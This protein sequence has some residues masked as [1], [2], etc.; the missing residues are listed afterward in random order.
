MGLFD[1]VTGMLGSQEGE[2]G[3]LQAI[4]AWLNDQGGIAGLLEKFH[5]GGLGTVIES[6]V[7]N[8]SNLPISGDQITAVLGTPAIADLASRLGI[9]TQNASHLIAEHL[10]NVVDGLSPEGQIN[11]Q[12]D[13]LSQ[14]L[15]MLKGKLSG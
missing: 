15:A 4:L 14:G 8:G 11:G 10:P 6:W 12:Q 3:T 2:A 9:D 5:Q 13:L 1:H 7:S